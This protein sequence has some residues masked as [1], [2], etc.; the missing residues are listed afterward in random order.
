MYNVGWCMQ[1]YY[2]EVFQSKE[3]VL[4]APKN[5]STAIYCL[6]KSPSSKVH[7]HVYS[8]HHL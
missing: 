5:T 6:P 3:G 8:Y 1:I 7:A 4:T 2:K